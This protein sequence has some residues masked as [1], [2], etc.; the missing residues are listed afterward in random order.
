MGKPSA[1]SDP[2]WGHRQA[3]EGWPPPRGR[4]VTQ[5]QIRGPGTWDPFPDPPYHLRGHWRSLTDPPSD[6]G[7]AFIIT[8]I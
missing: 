5:Y 7:A 4:W 8:G 2:E 3:G 6:P 1:R